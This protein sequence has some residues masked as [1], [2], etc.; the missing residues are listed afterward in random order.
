VLCITHLPQVAVYGHRHLNVSKTEAEDGRLVTRVNVLHDGDEQ[1]Q[2]ST[3][4]TEIASML[5]LGEDSARD[6]MRAAAADGSHR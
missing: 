4:L 2:G 3:R 5:H 6:L 1:G